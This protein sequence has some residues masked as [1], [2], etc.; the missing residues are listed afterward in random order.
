MLGT[1]KPGGILRIKICAIARNE[2]PYLAQWIFHHSF[3]GVTDF[4]IWVN[5]SSDSSMRV[6][7]AISDAGVANLEFVEASE[8]FDAAQEVGENF[9]FQAYRQMFSK[10]ADTF[11][12]LMFLDLDEFL[13]TSG[14]N[15]SLPEFLE[16]L[17][18][19]DA[20]G[21]P[22]LIDN[23]GES[24]DLFRLPIDF[25]GG[26]FDPHVKTVFKPQVASD[27]FV[28][29][30][31]T[32]S[33]RYVSPSGNFFPKSEPS[34]SGRRDF[35]TLDS[36]GK[37]YRE[38][39]ILHAMHRTET[40]YLARLGGGRVDPKLG[41]IKS[42][43]LG[44]LTTSYDMMLGISGET[45]VQY[46]QRYK[47]FLKVCAIS[48]NDYDFEGEVKSRHKDALRLISSEGAENFHLQLRGLQSLKDELG[49]GTSVFLKHSIDVSE[50]GEDGVVTI[51][52]WA[53]D[54]LGHQKLDFVI[55]TPEGLVLAIDRRA[56][57]RPDVLKAFPDAPSDCGFL[58]LTS[59]KLSASPSPFLNLD[60]RANNESVAEVALV[61]KKRKYE[62]VVPTS[63]NEMWDDSFQPI[64]PDDVLSHLKSK[65]ATASTFLEYGSGG[66]TYM[67]LRDF[68][69]LKRLFS[70]ESD[71]DWCETLAARI[72]KQESRLCLVW[73]DIGRTKD[74]GHPADDSMKDNFATYATAIWDIIESE[75]SHP[76]LVLIDGRFRV[77][78]FVMTALRGLPGA[79][80]VFD[81][82]MDRSHYHDV[83]RLVAREGVIG[84]AALF[85]IPERI[86]TNLAS[87]LFALFS[88]DPR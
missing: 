43:R 41:A 51:S 17:S 22:W 64:L 36:P 76:D 68:P 58:I 47:E 28:H 27:V 23:P 34:S 86:D 24:Q 37:E 85:R 78:S 80:I 9:Q 72:N 33:I 65:L 8:A 88:R 69:R 7:Q 67:A 45:Q 16:T 12:Y 87:E 66:S 57:S 46:R 15:L 83:E 56:V 63:Q 62:V 44:F 25:R 20:V 52:G 55:S 13:F 6:L 21:F 19:P 31:E 42:N 26:V 32:E 60:I 70:V 10:S 54:W 73:A 75:K 82:Y 48:T 39:F 53:Y 35:L 71:K 11:D 2:A 14:L 49:L 77:A 38:A 84:R 79:E 81:D 5:R 50:V 29:S 18:L 3:L 30:I 4:E 59:L 74:F 40:E 1:K 61:L